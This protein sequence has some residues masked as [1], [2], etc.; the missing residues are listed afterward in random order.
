M[1]LFSP[2]RACFLS[3][4]RWV[5]A[6]YGENPV[7]ARDSGLNT[8]PSALLRTS[9]L[10]SDH[11]AF[12]GQQAESAGQVLSGSILLH[13]ATPLRKGYFRLRLL[14]KLKVAKI[15]PLPRPW[16]KFIKPSFT[17]RKVSEA[18]IL[19]RFHPLPL[20]LQTDGVL[21]DSRFYEC[22]FQLPLPGDLTESIDGLPELS[23]QYRLEATIYWPGGHREHAYKR[24]RII[25][26]VA[27]DALEPFHAE[28][29]QKVWH[30]R[31][32]YCL[33]IPSK[34]VSF[35]GTIHLSI[36]AVALL[37]GL[38]LE[39]V[40]VELTEDRELRTQ[41]GS[42][43]ALQHRS[44]R[45][46]TEARFDRQSCIPLFSTEPATSALPSWDLSVPL[47]LPKNLGECTQDVHFDVFEVV[48]AVR[49]DMVMKSPSG[50]ESKVSAR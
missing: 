9:R 45:V 30:E 20:P 16:H 37:A 28:V 2:A 47:P 33:S 35:G 15:D 3:A 44:K 10:H 41:S 14:A 25:R 29:V 23:L 50:N 26:A 22:P 40:T 13:K 1:P 46:L 8:D 24:L 17:R 5:V 19:E 18:P 6:K 7:A 48:H 36:R 4:S 12:R 31:F 39:H 34:V 32:E 38:E 42:G 49:V 21:P 27:T 43:H 11:I